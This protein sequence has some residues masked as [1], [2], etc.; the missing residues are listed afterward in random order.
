[1]IVTQYTVLYLPCACQSTR[2][3]TSPAL[4]SFCHCNIRQAALTMDDSEG[5][6]Y[7]LQTNGADFSRSYHLGDT[8][9]EEEEEPIDSHSVLQVD[10]GQV[11]RSL[12]PHY[13]EYSSRRSS[14]APSR[15][16]SCHRTP[17]SNSLRRSASFNHTMEQGARRAAMLPRSPIDV[18]AETQIVST[19]YL[20]DLEHQIHDLHEKLRDH[21]SRN[22]QLKYVSRPFWAKMLIF[23][24]L[25]DCFK[26][27][28]REMN[29]K[30]Q[31]EPASSSSS[32]TSSITANRHSWS[33]SQSSPEFPSSPVTPPMLFNEQ[34]RGP[35]RYWFRHEWD[36]VDP[37]NKV[38]RKK[39]VT[40][41]DENDLS[42]DPSA[43]FSGGTRGGTDKAHGINRQ[44]L[45]VELE[46]GSIIDGWHASRI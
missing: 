40:D 20:Q 46:N 36:L 11:S 4:T 29:R 25:S 9:D 1:M 28:L 43:A 39:G 14:P 17:D 31:N 34:N 41:P 8:Y 38:H 37:T 7:S 10:T 27:M 42:V 6:F 16:N 35:I 5:S 15:S 22:A 33:S 3:V 23:I 32:L 19:Q 12:M 18:S 24:A 45:W 13:R 21:E 2:G 26:A 44:M 30:S